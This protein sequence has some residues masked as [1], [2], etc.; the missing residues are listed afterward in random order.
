MYPLLGSGKSY[1]MMGTGSDDPAT[2]G[3]IPRICD[4]L[5]AKI[6]EVS[7]ATPILILIITCIFIV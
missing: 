2:K 7:L 5:F 3:L 6:L 1:T 4:A